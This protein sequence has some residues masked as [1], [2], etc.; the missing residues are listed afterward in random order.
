M[1]VVGYG[2]EGHGSMT[3][4]SLRNLDLYTFVVHG[5]VLNSAR[6]CQSTRCSSVGTD[7]DR[8][9]Q[10]ALLKYLLVKHSP[11]NHPDQQATLLVFKTENRIA[12][13]GN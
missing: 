8:H 7:E 11:E 2:H 1:L 10:L 3:S 12:T 9:L 5:K 13:S 4:T 6:G